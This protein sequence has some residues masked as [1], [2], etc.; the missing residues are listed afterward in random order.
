M[1]RIINRPPAETRVSTRDNF[2]DC[3]LRHQYFRR[4]KFNPTFEEMQPYYKIAVTFAQKTFFTYRPLFLMIGLEKEDL[5][6]IAHV[7]IVN[8]LGLFSLEN[9]PDKYS[10]FASSFK[11]NHGRKPKKQDLLDKNQANFTM[12][13][14]QRMEDVVRICRQKV[15]NIKGFNIE[16]YFY[17]YGTNTPPKRLTDLIKNHDRLG[18]R[19]MESSVYKSIRKKAKVFDYEPFMIGNNYYIAVPVGKKT[20]TV[21]D[22][23]GAGMNPRDTLHNMDPEEVYATLEE[24]LVWERRQELFDSK[25]PQ[26]KAN[27]IRHFIRRNKGKRGYREE[28]KTARK[29]LKELEGERTA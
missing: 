12:F 21:E 9:L 14:K 3:Y 10:D 6:N 24:N 15:K 13:L 8:F 16:N 17:Y 23:N 25:T 26:A 20:L 27:I 1:R 18:F 28:I 22:L 2:E 5:I 7:H 11:S 29:L 4:V 19:K